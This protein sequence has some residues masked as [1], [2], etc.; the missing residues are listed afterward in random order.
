MGDLPALAETVP[1]FTR[2]GWKGLL[3]P[4]GTPRAIIDKLHATMV[5]VATTREARE[6]FALQGSEV[7][8]SDGA[9]MKR[10]LMKEIDDTARVVKAAGLKVE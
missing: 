4:R 6:Q 8:V 3:A 1:G 9:E 10:L 2:S 5:A 7:V